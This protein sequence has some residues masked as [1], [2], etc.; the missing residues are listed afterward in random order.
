M[1]TGLTVWVAEQGVYEDRYVVGVYSSAEKAMAA[2]PLPQ[3]PT[4]E[5]KWERD[6][7]GNWT[8]GGWDDDY[9]CVSPMVVDA[10]VP[11][12]V[13]VPRDRT[14]DGTSEPGS[15]KTLTEAT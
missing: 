6:G 4:R 2:H 14:G 5:S 8:N 7:W 13:S 1:E 15:Q 12:P 10:D 11:E 9:V 3:R